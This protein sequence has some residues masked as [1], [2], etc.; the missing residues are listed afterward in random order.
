MTSVQA[1][2][3]QLT[4]SG[5]WQEAIALLSEQNR[6]RPD[7]VQEKQLIDWRVQGFQHTAHPSPNTVWPP[8]FASDS[9][10]AF[11][12]AN[13]IPEITA[14]QLNANTLGA[15]V[16]QHGSLLVRNLVP[17]NMLDALRDNIEQAVN[18]RNQRAAGEV[19]DSNNPYYS[20]S[21][22]LNTHH[23]LGVGRKFI[24][25]TGGV[26]AADSPRGLI[27]RSAL[28]LCQKMGAAPRRSYC[29]RS[30]LAPRRR[31]YGQRSAQH[32]FM[33]RAERL[34]WRFREPRH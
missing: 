20:P 11:S 15:A 19:I 14:T 9:S 33:D 5:Q 18:T 21:Q 1:Q 10:N 2:A 32:E 25:E 16:Q 3:A 13:G 6:L 7:V 28:C 8:V 31:V 17:K 30:R 4:E 23:K 29:R 27:W 22:Y 26:W 24:A 12:L 34:R